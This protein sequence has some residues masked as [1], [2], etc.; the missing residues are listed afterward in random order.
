MVVVFTARVL[1]PVGRGQIGSLVFPKVRFDSA[2][3]LASPQTDVGTDRNLANTEG[4]E[5]ILRRTLFI[6]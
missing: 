6:N 4:G 3:S 2:R 1:S 5:Q